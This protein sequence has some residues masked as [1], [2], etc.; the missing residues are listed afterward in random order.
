MHRH[1]EPS[2]YQP[3]G[4]DTITSIKPMPA[5]WQARVPPPASVYPSR[6]WAPDRGRG[7][8]TVALPPVPR[9][10]R[11]RRTLRWTAGLFIGGIAATGALFTGAVFAAAIVGPAPASH[12]RPSPAAATAA[13][14]PRPAH[15]TSTGYRVLFKLNGSAPTGLT[16]VSYGSAGHPRTPAASVPFTASLPWHPH[17]AYTIT[18]QLYGPGSISDSVICRRIDHLS[19]GSRRVKDTTVALGTAARDGDTATATW[20]Q[21]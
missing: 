13:A 6:Y 3:A 1:T 5:G 19:D 20:E 17:T 18:G 16:S 7:Q 4:D 14:S 11:I 9:P 2:G 12:P 8:Q 15:I 10:R 21:T